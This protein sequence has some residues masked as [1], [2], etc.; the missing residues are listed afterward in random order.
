MKKV[1]QDNETILPTYHIICEYG[2]EFEQILKFC[3]SGKINITIENFFELWRLA[4]FFQIPS[5]QEVLKTF[6][7]SLYLSPTNV[8]DITINA[9]KVMGSV[10]VIK[11]CVSYFCPRMQIMFSTYCHL[12]SLEFLQILFLHNDL[13]SLRDSVCFELLL[14]WHE[15][16][17]E[18]LFEQFQALLRDHMAW[19]KMTDEF[20]ADHVQPT[21]ILS[22]EELYDIFMYKSTKKQKD[23]Y[24]HVVFNLSNRV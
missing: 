18:V 5:L 24:Q 9:S 21:N 16:H 2:E 19:H 20:L 14:G 22:K 10:E 3:Y 17:P 12:I 4:D 11:K 1:K 15:K 7:L 8:C 6:E 23:R 13:H